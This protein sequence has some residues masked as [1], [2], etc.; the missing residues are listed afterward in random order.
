MLKMTMAV[1]LALVAMVAGPAGAQ[2][3]LGVYADAAGTSSVV[4]P[5]EGENFDVYVVL[6]VE[7]LVDAVSYELVAPGL[8]TDFVALSTVYGPEGGGIN[9][10]TPNGENVGLGECAVG[11][12]GNPVLVTKYTFFPINLSAS[13]SQISVTGNAD[14]NDL[15][16]VYSNC[17][18]AVLDCAA[19]PELI[20]DSVVATESA[21]FGAVKSLYHN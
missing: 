2:C 15:V 3:T 20:V 18:G 8:G 7:S 10:S 21:S 19:G 4:Q 6:F 16:P 5:V 13:G 11:Y 12:N 1:A 14:E 17:T 9:I